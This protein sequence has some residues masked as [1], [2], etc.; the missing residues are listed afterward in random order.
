M[1]KTMWETCFG[2]TRPVECSRATDKTVWIMEQP[3]HG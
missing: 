1:N 3:W 2:K